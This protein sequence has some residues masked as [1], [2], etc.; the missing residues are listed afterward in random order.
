[1]IVVYI[2][3]VVSDN[4]KRSSFFFHLVNAAIVVSPWPNMWKGH[5][6]L[7]PLVSFDWVN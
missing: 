1:M 5:M 7:L 4:C 2:C 6:P 3:V